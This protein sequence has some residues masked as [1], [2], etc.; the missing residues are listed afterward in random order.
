MAQMVGSV[1]ELMSRRRVQRWQEDW[2][3]DISGPVLRSGETERGAWLTQHFATW[4]LPEQKSA[5]NRIRKQVLSEPTS[6]LNLQSEKGV[7]NTMLVLRFLQDFESHLDRMNVK[8][9]PAAQAQPQ[10][11]RDE[12]AAMELF[13]RPWVITE[14]E[15]ELLRL[16]EFLDPTTRVFCAAVMPCMLPTSSLVAWLME[17][18]P[19]AWRRLHLVRVF[20]P[21]LFACRI[22][23]DSCY[24]IE[25]AGLGLREL[26]DAVVQGQAMSMVK[27]AIPQLK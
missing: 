17:Q 4:D 12:W 24:R 2:P 18:S 15:T 20:G 16:E 6:H 22:R 8:N 11:D 21:Q 27:G 25:S 19:R 9:Q 14:A 26:A 7:R 10:D 23:L 3:E 13:C 5:L 1:R